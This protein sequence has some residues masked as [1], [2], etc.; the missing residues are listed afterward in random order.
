M[1]WTIPCII[2]Y[3]SYALLSSLI[4]S[5]TERGYIPKFQNIPNRFIFYN[6]YGFAHIQ[7]DKRN[8]HPNI[9]KKI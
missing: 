5:L 4:R 2:I 3:T 6:S 7:L 1:K 9:I 8:F